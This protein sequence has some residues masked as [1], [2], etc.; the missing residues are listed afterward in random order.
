MYMKYEDGVFSKI[1]LYFDLV[2]Y[3][4][5]NVLYVIMIMLNYV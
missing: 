5:L 4:K 2:V 3:C 1:I